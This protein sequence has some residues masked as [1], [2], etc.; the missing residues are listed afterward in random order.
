M[1]SN[2]GSF[3]LEHEVTPVLTYQR[4]LQA[5]NLNRAGT[6]SQP[7]YPPQATVSGPS[8]SGNPSYY[9]YSSWPSGWPSVGGYAYTGNYQVPQQGSFVQ[10]NV[11]SDVAQP[12]SI[13][14]TA[15]QAHIS[16][17]P[18]PS[19]SSP[20]PESYRHWDEVILLFLKRLGLTQ[21]VAGFEADILVMNTVWEQ[22]KVPDALTELSR[23]ISVGILPIS[24]S[25]N[26]S[27][28]AVARKIYGR[29]K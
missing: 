11:S 28:H 7:Y 10:Y 14:G 18:V 4:G 16:K 3:Q 8:S 26:S 27:P 12:V 1:T 25:Y 5:N 15:P 13:P 29:G 19:P 22:K 17:S 24:R 20:P 9:S 6:S 21:A 23:N 2:T